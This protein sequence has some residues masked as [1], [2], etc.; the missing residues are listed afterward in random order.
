M[1]IFLFIFDA[2][3]TSAAAQAADIAG[4][5]ITVVVKAADG[6]EAELIARSVVMDYAW[7]I[8]AVEDARGPVGEQWRES[9]TPGGEL[10]RRADRDGWAMEIAA[11]P[12]QERAEDSGIDIRYLGPRKPPDDREH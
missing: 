7:R 3:P 10:F 12:K 2:E 8:K 11:W 6:E 9:D 5:D 4:A 1:P